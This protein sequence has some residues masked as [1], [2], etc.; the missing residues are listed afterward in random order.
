MSI[1]LKTP[2]WFQVESCHPN[3]VTEA[4]KAKQP[5]S[6]TCDA[7]ALT[8]HVKEENE[9]KY[10]TIDS[11]F[12][13]KQCNKNFEKL[14]QRFGIDDDNPI[15]VLL[16]DKREDEMKSLTAGVAAIILQDKIWVRFGQTQPVSLSRKH[17]EGIVDVDDLKSVI[18]E[19]LKSSLGG[20]SEELITLQKGETILKNST[21]VAELYNTEDEALDI[22]VK[23]NGSQSSSGKTKTESKKDRL[24]FWEE[25]FK[26]LSQQ[27]QHES[28]YND[29]NFVK[30]LFPN[31]EIS[32]VCCVD[33]AHELLEKMSKEQTHDETYFIQWRRQIRE[34][35]WRG[36]F[37][38]LLSTNG[39]IGNYLPPV[40]KDTQSA[41][42]YKF[43]LFPAFLDVHTI[44][45]FMKLA[46]PGNGYDPERNLYLGIPLWGSLYQ[47]GMNLFDILHL[48]SQKIHV[49]TLIASYMETAIGVSQDRTD[50]LCA[51]PSDPILSAGALK[52][53]VDVG[54]ED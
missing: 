35:K 53:I 19:H 44:D 7:T 17:L 49:D 13:K 47:A 6:I 52:G 1:T 8:L 15:N 39:K 48:A 46:Q 10:T 51:Y 21:P 18:K 27:S 20:I 29:R 24:S 23:E 43:Y 28:N 45:V 3:K 12:F 33:E 4:I 11:A 26:S 16:P 36:F 2:I 25:I 38:I 37:N 9:S 14:I 50:L 40:I 41:R 54:C 5:V 34:I 22:I 42:S 30:D 31:N 32:I